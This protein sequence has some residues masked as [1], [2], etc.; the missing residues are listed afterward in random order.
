MVRVEGIGLP[1]GPVHGHDEV[2]PQPFPERV[3]ADERLEL[4][5]Q[6]AVAPRGQF[7]RQLRLQR[8]EIFLAKANRLRGQRGVGRDPRERLS[9]PQ[10]DRVSQCPSRCRDVIAP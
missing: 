6:L 3:L 8:P 9:P 1:A 4:A 7:C 2:T 5:D 10:R